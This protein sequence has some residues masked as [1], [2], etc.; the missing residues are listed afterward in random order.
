M[1]YEIGMDVG[2][3][4]VKLAVFSGRGAKARFIGF[5][6]YD[7][8]AEGVL[9]EG[10]L[11]SGVSSLLNE[12][13]LKGASL[14]V[15][16]PQYQVTASIQDYP[17]VKVRDLAR[18]VALD[19]MQVGGLS[20][21]TF[22]HGFCQMPGGF[23]RS[24]PVL[25]C[26][27]REDTVRERVEGVAK[28]G[29]QCESVAASGLALAV[30]GFELVPE[31]RQCDEPAVL[32]DIGQEN[33]TLTVV[34]GGQVVYLGSLMFGAEKFAAVAADQLSRR[35]S[36][37]D[38][39]AVSAY[40][41]ELVL[42]DE[43]GQSPIRQAANLLESEIQNA[44]E[45]WRS[46]EQELLAG[47]PITHMYVSGGGSR[48]GGLLPWLES[49]LECKVSLLGPSVDSSVRPDLTIAYGLGL[50]A[51]GKSGYVMDL[52]PDDIVR[53]RLRLKRWPFLAA[54]AALVVGTMLGY[55]VVEALAKQGEIEDLKERRKQLSQYVDMASSLRAVRRATVREEELLASLV[56]EGERSRLVVRG[57]QQAVGAEMPH[58][59]LI[60]LADGVTAYTPGLFF[61]RVAGKPS[62]MP[63]S[64]RPVALEQRDIGYKPVPR[65]LSFVCAG[66]VSTSHVNELRSLMS[67]L[68]GKEGA[69][70]LFKGVDRS[71]SISDSSSDRG[72]ELVRSWRG[73]LNGEAGRIKIP[74][75][76]N[77]MLSDAFELF[78][79]RLPI[80]SS[81]INES[82]FQDDGE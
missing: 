39:A 30:A 26:L 74:V 5:E 4:G 61:K 2:A 42:D 56:K 65:S 77:G 73:Y 45:H 78:T 41:S 57:V 31:L 28:A 53:S 66:F 50:L 1:N 22:V 58:G 3:S 55:M 80:S 40:L 69:G 81:G 13:K 7:A 10:E 62:S 23:G 54:S 37:Q 24:F 6:H 47:T 9:S 17:Q 21:E 43:A 63:M 68:D 11:Y 44:V 49:I 76:E 72:A 75:P 70:R 15:G 20:D 67:V 18:L 46:Q 64:S 51:C 82:R 36:S 25:M 27:A 32:L 59:W 34:V 71:D 19:A 79:L 14:C 29:L 52:L 8:E 60:Y 48:L 33:T 38:A 16:L 35:K 12:R